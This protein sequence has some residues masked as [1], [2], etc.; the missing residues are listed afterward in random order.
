VSVA[1]PP[2]RPLHFPLAGHASVS[3]SATGADLHCRVPISMVAAALGG[4]FEVPTID[5]G[6]GPK[7]KVPFRNSVGAGAFASHQR[8]CR[9]CARVR[10]ETCY[11]QVR[12][13]KRLRI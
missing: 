2:G 7:V 11:V 1:G 6:Q 9:C 8:V 3:F 12:G 4:E 10:P 13:S 5:K